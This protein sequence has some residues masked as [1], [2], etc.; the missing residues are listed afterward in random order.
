[1]NLSTSYDCKKKIKTNEYPIYEL[2]Y[3]NQCNRVLID[4]F[5]T[6]AHKTESQNLTVSR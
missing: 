1:M 6:N 4:M 5:Y 2:A 3:I